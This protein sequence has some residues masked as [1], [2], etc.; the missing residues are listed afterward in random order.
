MYESW[1]RKE[2]TARL[3]LSLAML[4]VGAGLLGA[5]A[6][7][8]G[9]DAGAPIRNGGTFRI[10][11]ISG[12]GNID[13]ALLDGAGFDLIEP[14]CARVMAYPDKA[15]PQGFRL[16]PDV[17]SRVPRL[18]RDGKTYTFT[19]RRGVRFSN[20]APVRA[21]AFAWAITRTLR[22]NQGDAIQLVQDIVGADRV[23]EGKAQTVTGITAR[24]N[25]LVIRLTRPAPAFPARLAAPWFCAVP[26]SLPVDPEGV[27]TFPAAGPYYVAE[28]VRGRRIVLR[29]NRFY[30]GSRPHHVVSFVADGQAGSF[31]EVLDRIERGTADWGQVPPSEQLQRGLQK[32]YGV[33]R[34][35]FFLKPGLVF[36]HYHFNTSRPLFRNNARLRRAV[37][38][39]VNRAA[40]RAAWEGRLGSRLTDQYL[41]PGLFGFRDARIYPLDRPD[42]RRARALASGHRRSGKAVL[43]TFDF[44]PSIAAAQV[45]KKN[46]ATIGLA[47]EVKGIPPTAYYQRIAG[48]P[49]EPWDIAYADWA[50]DHLDPYTYLNLLLDGQFARENNLSHFNSPKYNRLL[51]RTARLRGAAR[52]RAYA[53]LDVRLARDAAP[54]LAIGYLN[55]ATFISKRVDRRCIV[56]RP[57]LVLDA[58]CL[59]R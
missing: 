59:K 38:F 55:D 47:V 34:S 52:Y 32:K 51:R 10:A 56:L 8:R 18:S 27:T 37:N 22:L 57:T 5:A 23:L 54:I 25:R 16:A 2:T 9:G 39:A 11:A 35:R 12:I 15:P 14:T 24:G 43:Y 58:V 49:A 48:N 36:R 30:R 42:A 17:A 7:A 50:P 28:N 4:A 21:S 1:Q 41:P 19:L 44:P 45:I 33:N 26:P 40:V 46:L 6:T 31:E 53:D 3:Y 13:P 29:R 20:G